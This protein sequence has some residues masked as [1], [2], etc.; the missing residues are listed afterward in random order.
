MKLSLIFVNIFIFISLYS[1]AHRP[2]YSI[3]KEGN[4][5]LRFESLKRYGPERLDKLGKHQKNIALCQQM[6][7]NTSL[8]NFKEVLDTNLNNFSYWNQIGTCYIRQKEYSKAI[9]FLNLA[10]KTAK[11]KK[12]KSIT[13]NNF[14]VIYLEKKH[15][16][17]ALEYFKESQKNSPQFL[18][19]RYNSTQIYLKFSLYQ[20]AEKEII[21]LLKRN[22][23][24]IDF[25]YSFGH[26]KLMQNKYKAAIQNFELIPEQYRSRDDIATNMAMTYLMLGD[27]DRALSCIKRA[28]K[29]VVYFTEAQSKILKF[30]KK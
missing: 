11:T 30:I 3:S 10:L 26:L 1:C 12:Q 25:I 6:S 28:N 7:Y 23:K 17:I 21:W 22:S 15:F 14:G 13:L 4:D 19:P 24:D 9:H 29:S 16:Q 2:N 8:A 27:A 18:T 20:K 5:A